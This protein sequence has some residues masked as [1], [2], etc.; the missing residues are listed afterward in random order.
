MISIGQ[1][2]SIFLTGNESTKEILMDTKQ[3]IEEAMALVDEAGDKNLSEG[4]E[5]S[6]DTVILMPGNLEQVSAKARLALK[7]WIKERWGIKAMKGK[8][9]GH[10]SH[11]TEA[12][13][14]KATLS[15]LK[16]LGYK[17][18]K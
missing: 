1:S 14:H 13:Y 6:S 11:A 16:D 8:K 12:L 3:K 2:L 18:R 15:Y 7:G 9:W 10:P 4:Y 17:V 5:A